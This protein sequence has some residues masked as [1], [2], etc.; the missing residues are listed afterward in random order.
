MA[1][2]FLLWIVDAFLAQTY[3]NN[4]LPFEILLTKH[5]IIAETNTNAKNFVEHAKRLLFYLF[6]WVAG[7]N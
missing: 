2:L 6:A 7:L 3:C 4:S 1:H 5:R